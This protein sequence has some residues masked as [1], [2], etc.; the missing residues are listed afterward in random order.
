MKKPHKHCELIKAWADGLEIEFLSKVDGKWWSVDECDFNT[1]DEA[2]EYRVKPEAK[3]DVV[4]F[5]EGYLDE[6]KYQKVPHL[7]A[8]SQINDSLHNLKLTFDGETGKL[9]SAE[10]INDQ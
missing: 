10:V 5:A 3:P 1:W 8:I 7:T 9:K 4:W 6:F 2:Y